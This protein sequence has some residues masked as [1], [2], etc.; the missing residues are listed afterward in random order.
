MMSGKTLVSVL[1][2]C[3]LLPT[4]LFPFVLKLPRLIEFEIVVGAWWLVWSSV[5]TTLL[6]K[7][8]HIREDV[9]FSQLRSEQKRSWWEYLDFVELAEGFPGLIISIIVSVLAALLLPILVEFV[10]PVFAWIAYS[11]VLK[12]LRTAAHDRHHCEKN[13]PRSAGYGIMW[14]SFYL[15]PVIVITLALHLTMRPGG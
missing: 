15:L 10:F 3:L 6:Y 11:L 7:G 1:I 9:S 8:W 2:G 4:F 5:L 12:M 13:L 14:A